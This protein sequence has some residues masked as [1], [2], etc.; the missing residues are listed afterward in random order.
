MWDDTDAYKISVSGSNGLIYDSTTNTSRLFIVPSNITSGYINVMLQS[1]DGYVYDLEIVLH[2]IE[3][4]MNKNK[5]LL[6]RAFIEVFK[7]DLNQNNCR[8]KNNCTRL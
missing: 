5:E 3:G 6:T 2:D 7:E 4:A 8:C 1:R